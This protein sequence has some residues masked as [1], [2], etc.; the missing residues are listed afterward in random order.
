M[1][2]RKPFEEADEAAT[3]AMSHEVT[4][5]SW[6]LFIQP[7]NPEPGLD[8]RGQFLW[9]ETQEE[10]LGFLE[11]DCVYWVGMKGGET[12][13]LPRICE[14][15]SRLTEK[16]R[17]GNLSYVEA[18]EELSDWLYEFN[19]EITWAGAFKELVIGPNEFPVEV[20]SWFRRV[21]EGE[22]RRIVRPEDGV[23]LRKEEQDGFLDVL[24]M[25]GELVD[26]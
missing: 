15:A 25:Y 16:I 14:E 22:S 20:R 2:H 23:P 19:R 5:S 11:Q 21:V 18:M 8:E 1:E 9:F 24:G 13:D 3:M 10:L 7:A 4:E 17:A 12:E 6:G 26:E